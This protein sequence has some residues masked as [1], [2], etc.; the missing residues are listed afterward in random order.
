M[1]N[2]RWS[3]ARTSIGL[4]YLIYFDKSVISSC[5]FR[6]PLTLGLSEK[7]LREPSVA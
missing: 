4:L 3:R 1:T 2:D 7:F 6:L 5:F